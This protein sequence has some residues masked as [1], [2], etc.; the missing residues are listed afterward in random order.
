MSEDPQFPKQE[1]AIL[2]HLVHLC[3]LQACKTLQKSSSL[4]LLG[5]FLMDSTHMHTHTHTCTHARTHGPSISASLLEM[6]FDNFL[7][8]LMMRNTPLISSVCAAT[9]EHFVF[10][11]SLSF[12]HIFIVSSTFSVCLQPWGFTSW[13]II[14]IYVRPANVLS[15]LPWS[16]WKDIHSVPHVESGKAAQVD[17]R[18][19]SHRCWLNSHLISGF[20]SGFFYLRLIT[21]SETR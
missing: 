11:S 15:I 7:Y 2:L 9:R 20:G 12:T 8:K 1:A 5:V 3:W 13:W 6:I 16:S 10:L 4:K 17:R 21:R 19:S 14:I 18:A